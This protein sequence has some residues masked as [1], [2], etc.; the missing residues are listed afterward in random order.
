MKCPDAGSF[1]S[2]FVEYHVD[3]RLA[4]VGINLSKNLGCDFD[5]IAFQLAFI[6]LGK[7][8]GELR[9]IHLQDVFE[10][11]IRFADQ[12]DIA[13]LDAVVDHLDVMT[14]A[15][16]AHVPATRFAIHLRSNFAENRRDTFP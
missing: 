3:E 16:R 7:R 1:L 9:S 12:L 13:V 15:A 5:E 4:G 6:P 2:R 11:R 10:N 8:V 14:G